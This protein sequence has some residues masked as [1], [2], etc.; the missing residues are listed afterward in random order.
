MVEE[1]TVELFSGEEKTFSLIASALGYKT[2][3]VDKNPS[4]SPSL[5]A[6]VGD[7][8]AVQL[9]EKPLIV[10][11]APPCRAFAAASAWK[12]GEP[13]T[14]EAEDALDLLGRTITLIAM[15]HPTWWFLETPKSPLRKMPLMA[16]F[17]RGYPSRNRHT[18]KHD[19]YGGASGRETDIWTNA[20]WWLPRPAEASIGE[21]NSSRRVPPYAIAE[22]LNQLDAYRLAKEDH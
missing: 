4:F 16:G 7:L 9:P 21:E 18:I 12:S 22:I 6:D 1:Q 5:V 19:E 11:A 20:F 15:T 2:F 10:W 17:N 14:P 13:A 3:T 8:K